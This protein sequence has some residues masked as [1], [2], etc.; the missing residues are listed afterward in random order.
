VEARTHLRHHRTV[1]RSARSASTLSG[2]V[3]CDGCHASTNGTRS[4]GATTKSAT[5]VIPA[6]R[7]ATGVRRYTASGP[8]IAV[9]EP[10]ARRTQG[11]VEP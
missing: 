7:V 2:A 5:V 10:S 8:A 9:S 1:D 3:T 6:P 4:P 11:T